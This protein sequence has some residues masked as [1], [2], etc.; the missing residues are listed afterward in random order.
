MFG[1]Y[2]PLAGLR[3]RTPRLEL[4]V[5]TPDD[6][7]ALAGV[8]AAGV[9]EAERMPFLT[10]WTVGE[11]VEVGRRF[12]QYQWRCWGEWSP[13]RWQL[14]LAA[15]V[16]GT[17]VGVQGVNASDYP[18]TREA[19]TGS[20]LGLAHQGRGIGTEMRA[21]IVHLA[22]AGLEA[23]YVTSGAFTDNPASAAVSRKIGYQ[24]DGLLRVARGGEAADL[25]RLRLD[26]ASWERR[27][28]DDIEIS[29]LAE[30]RGL[31]GLE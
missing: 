6:L 16:D 3:V 10:P 22:F 14:E 23:E 2:W 19:E 5:P 12:L 26:R 20:W 21:A 30:C 8:A 31:F 7:L 24:P 27:R 11:P 15:V 25:L 28:R 18:V 29:G 4:R 9:H 1:E 13:Q 17:P